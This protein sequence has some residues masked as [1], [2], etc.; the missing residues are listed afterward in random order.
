MTTQ[1]ESDP[2][3]WGRL[4]ISKRL[5]NQHRRARRA[6]QT[7]LGLRPWARE[8]A[9]GANST[10]RQTPADKLDKTRSLSLPALAWHWLE[11]RP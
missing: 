5:R 9:V 3:R 8:L 11:S 1:T 10:E 6:H 2:A 7:T 4:R